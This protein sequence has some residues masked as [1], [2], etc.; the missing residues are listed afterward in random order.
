MQAFGNLISSLSIYTAVVHSV[1]VLRI[2][3]VTSAACDYKRQGRGR[4]WR[5]GGNGGGGGR[6]DS[7]LLNVTPLATRLV[8]RTIVSNEHG[9]QSSPKSL[10]ACETLVLGIAVNHRF[11]YIFFI[12][13]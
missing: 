8:L 2:H 12:I 4:E 1:V 13:K 11:F 3:W 7:T 10:A 5:G 6:Q 9:H